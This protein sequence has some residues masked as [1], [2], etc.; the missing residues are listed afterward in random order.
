MKSK[1]N[2]KTSD[3][4]VTSNFQPSTFNFQPPILRWT[5]SVERW[6]LGVSKFFCMHCFAFF[7]F[8]MP[9]LALDAPERAFIWDEANAKMQ[10]A[11]TQ[12]DY[13]Q[14]A[15]TYQRLIDDGV[16]N[17]TLFYN[18]GTALLLADRPDPA[19]DAFERAERYLGRRPDIEH[20]LKIAMAK[21]AKSREAQA[22]W[23]RIL[24]FWH[25]YLSCPQR[26]AIAAFAFLIFWLALVLRHM[27]LKRFTN[28][29][30]LF[31]LVIF[32]VF[33]SSA[34][35]SWQMENSARRYDLNLIPVVT[36]TNSTAATA[37]N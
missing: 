33:A 36:P 28:T 5:L 34:A 26:S 23:Y 14:A 16:R 4:T 6:K 2:I 19:L 29:I 12:A 10:N 18:L 8:V 22:P 27:G 7:M 3:R 9:A 13:L 32:A 15:Q 31:S 24:A 1:K 17:G 37:S 20:N 35:A 11:Q 25:F 21:K 30:A